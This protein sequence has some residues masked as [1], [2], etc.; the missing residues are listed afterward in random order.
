MEQLI[1]QLKVLQATAFSLYLKAH[2]YHWNVTGPN[3]S[4]YHA[5]FGT[6]Y[7]DVWASVDMY[8][9]HARTL[10]TFV[11]GSLTRFAEL[12]KIQDEVNIPAPNAMFARL[13]ADNEIFLMELNK[14]HTMAEAVNK[15]GIVNF[16]E[17][18]IDFHE[19]MHWMLKSFIS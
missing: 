16:L 3:F 6:F 7:N 17:G 5:F 13:F 8:A 1:L 10:D 15:R 18:Q 9:E 12:T 14:A 2:N 11:P 4:D 19:K